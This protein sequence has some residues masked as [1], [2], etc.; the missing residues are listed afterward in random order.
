MRTQPVLKKV[1]DAGTGNGC[2]DRKIGCR[3]YL[4]EERTGRI[5]LHHLPVAL[6][7]PRRHCTTGE[8]AAQAGMA[9]QVARVLR[10]AVTFEIR[11]SCGSREAL[12]ARPDRNRNHVFFQPLAVADARVT[13]G[14]PT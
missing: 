4:D 7:L 8:A 9:Q 12:Y 11:G 6:E 10:P 1:Q 3:T 5:D 14:R 13:G 2:F